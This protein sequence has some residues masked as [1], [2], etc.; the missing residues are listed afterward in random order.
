MKRESVMKEKALRTANVRI[1]ADGEERQ[2]G[3]SR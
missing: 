2:D 3:S 1:P